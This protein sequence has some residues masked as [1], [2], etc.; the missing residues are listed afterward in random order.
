MFR[1]TGAFF[2]LLVLATYV[3]LTSLHAD[4]YGNDKAVHFLTFFL[5]T[6]AFY[7]ILDTNRR[8]T[9]H[10][11][12][13]VCTLA[14]GVGS[15][16]L[17]RLLPYAPQFDIWDTIANVLGSFAGLGLCSWYHKR[18][19]ERKRQRRGYNGVPG[20]DLED[21]DLE[22]GQGVGGAHEEGVI[23]GAGVDTSRTAT[24]EEVAK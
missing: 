1:T 10:I 23:N 6:L 12:I 15:E 11:T 2:L 5:L 9:T 24:L 16:I 18:M 14:L 21:D 13:I 22:L 17:Q 20:E 3:G 7:W 19:L 4:A 8:R